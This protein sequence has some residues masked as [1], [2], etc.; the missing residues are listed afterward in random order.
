MFNTIRDKVQELTIHG[1]S[2]DR[3]GTMKGNVQV[4][5]EVLEAILAIWF[6]PNSCHIPLQENG[7]RFVQKLQMA[8]QAGRDV[9]HLE[10]R[11][12]NIKKIKYSL[13]MLLFTSWYCF[14]LS[15]ML[16]KNYNSI[17]TLYLTMNSPLLSDKTSVLSLHLDLRSYPSIFI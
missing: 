16:I 9:Y 3:E 2:R 11:Y 10:N 7:G 12:F 15:L 13:S 6:F 17:G 8:L 4:T 14:I 5:T 1:K